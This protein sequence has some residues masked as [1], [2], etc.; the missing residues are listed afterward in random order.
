MLRTILPSALTTSAISVAPMTT[1]GMSILQQR[2]RVAGA[3]ALPCMWFIIFTI[4]LSCS[5]SSLPLPPSCN[6]LT[7]CRSLC[8]TALS[9]LI[10]RYLPA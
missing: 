3:S 4:L 1:S 5:N 6:Y 9:C 7:I 8:F 10:R 2:C